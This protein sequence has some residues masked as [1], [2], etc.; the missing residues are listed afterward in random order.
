MSNRATWIAD[1]FNWRSMILSHHDPTIIRSG[2]TS[3]LLIRHKF[4]KMEAF[5]HNIRHHPRLVLL[6][7]VPHTRFYTKETLNRR[8]NKAP[9][10]P[11][12]PPPVTVHIP[13]R[14]PLPPLP[15]PTAFG[16][17]RDPSSN[18]AKA[19]RFKESRRIE[20]ALRHENHGENIYAYKHI[21]TGQVVYSLTRVMDVCLHTDHY[22]LPH[23]LRFGG[24]Q[25][26][27]L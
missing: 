13:K 15:K 24:S 11:L 19:E 2:P 18:A 25:C 1:F 21:Q 12:R 14:I 8:R 27:P 5:S 9:A 10:R 4:Q 20:K 22:F 3:M 26:I 6:N 16:K 23:C 7:R 17:P